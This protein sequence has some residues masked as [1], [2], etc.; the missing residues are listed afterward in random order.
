METNT[1]N[2]DWAAFE[3][4][5]NYVKIVVGKPKKLTLDRVSQTTADIQEKTADGQPTVKK[6]P[7]LVFHAT[8]EDSQAV[9]KEFSVT[10][11]LLAK[12][13]RAFIEKGFPFTVTINSSGERFER[14]YEVVAA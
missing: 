6:V 4:A 8:M 11:K 7:V 9:D 1:Q 3:G 2:L 10:S 12:K 14:E 13:L 5:S